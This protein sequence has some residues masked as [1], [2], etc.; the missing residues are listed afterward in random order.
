ME[1]LLGLR[2]WIIVAIEEIIDEAFEDADHERLTEN[3]IIFESLA[4]QFSEKVN[5][6]INQKKDMKSNSH[7]KTL[8]NSNPVQN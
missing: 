7:E 5:T 8:L 3:K 4:S 1:G 2:K 6:I